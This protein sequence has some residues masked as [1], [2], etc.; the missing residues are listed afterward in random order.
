[1]TKPTPY[2]NVF[3]TKDFIRLYKN[4]NVRIQKAVDEKLQIFGKNPFDL[5]LRNHPLQDE[6]EGCRSIDITSDYRGADISV[7]GG[8]A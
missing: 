1:M 3:S 4:V 8:L 6:W 2:T 5:G 7:R